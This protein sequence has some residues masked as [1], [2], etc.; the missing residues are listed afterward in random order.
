MPFEWASCALG[1]LLVA[2]LAWLRSVVGRMQLQRR[3]SA[4]SAAT[5][6]A[7][8]PAVPPVVAGLPLLGSALALGSGGADFLRRCREQHGDAFTLRLLGQRM[9]F[10]FAPAA[11][12]RY[13]TAPDTLLTFA[14]AV[15]QFTHRVFGLPPKH[16]YPRHIVMLQTLRHELIPAALPQ[17]TARLL[18][19]LLPRVQAWP[20]A[21]QMELVSELKGLVF[22]A[23]VGALFGP[24]FLGQEA[25]KHG[26]SG[27][28][29][30]GSNAGSGGAVADGTSSS[31]GGGGVQPAANSRAR[32]LQDAF[33]AFEGGFEMAASPLPHLLQ[34]RFLA[35]RRT[36]LAALR[37]SHRAG[38]FEGT[39]AGTLI[40]ACGLPEEHVPNMLLALLWASQAN[41]VPTILWVLGLLLL[42][43]N[44][45]HLEAVV[46]EARQ[47]AG[48]GSASIGSPT[49]GGARAAAAVQG[50]PAAAAK[51]RSRARTRGQQQQQQ[52]QQRQNQEGDPA[53]QMLSEEQQQGLVELA[54]NR[55]SRV[56]AAISETLRLRC[57]SIDVRI[58]ASDGVLPGGTDG[59]G[60]GIWVQQGDVVA[61]SPYESHLDSRLYQDAPAAYNPGR[62]GMHLGG[63]TAAHAAVVGVGGVPGLAFGGGKYRCPGRYFAEAELALIAS[64]LLLLFDWR[65]LPR[66]GA[67]AHAAD[68]AQQHKAGTAEA[69]TAGTAAGA[70]AAAAAAT[71]AHAPP[72]DPAGLLPPPDL[73]KLV[74]IKVPAGPCWV[75]YERR[76]QLA[77]S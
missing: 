75:Q 10:V 32:R 69:I 40:Q 67:A 52:G 25:A 27:G 59:S 15:Q 43:E 14:P 41:A 33:F 64:L 37:E 19:L 36:L 23:S 21:G 51:A 61:I 46:A 65:L 35:A 73:R 74:G 68:Q 4:W 6:G 70:A 58:A 22:D 53:G 38:H 28:G 63:S 49:A 44:Q 18:R 11:L 71:A 45:Q 13:F 76:R 29:R 1:A 16:F 26:S 57:F 31:G 60:A 30:A 47:A 56:A 42:P 54:C 62:D 7:P 55:H 77:G 50:T 9:T 12:Q 66:E 48:L 5:K 3:L 24:R 39:V 72:G 20:A 8:P 34:P 2:L 17:H